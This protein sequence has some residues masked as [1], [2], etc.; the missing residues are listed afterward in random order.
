MGQPGS[1]SGWGK[2]KPQF[3]RVEGADL[4]TQAWLIFHLTSAVAFQGNR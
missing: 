3:D 4:Q 2:N 1:K